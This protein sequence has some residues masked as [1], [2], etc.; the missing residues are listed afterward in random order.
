MKKISIIIPV[1]NTKIEELKQCLNSIINQTYK[2]IEVIIVNDGSTKE[3]KEKYTEICKSYNNIKIINQKNSGVSEAR[4]NG[5]KNSTGEWIMFVDSDDWLELDAC[6]KLI[7]KAKDGVEI[8]I[9]RANLCST[10]KKATQ[11]YYKNDIL[12][13]ND[14]LKNELI[15]SIFRMPKAKYHYI[16]APWAKIYNKEFLINQKILFVKGL[17]FGEDTL[18]NFMAYSAA[19]KIYFLNTETYNY[20]LSPTSVSNKYNPKIIDHYNNLFTEYYKVL[21]DN[22]KET[23][24]NYFVFA[25]I[26]KYCKRYIFN[27]E[28]TN[29]DY[30]QLKSVFNNEINQKAINYVFSHRWKDVKI[31][32]VKYR[33]YLY[34]VRYQKIKLLK[35]Y[36]KIM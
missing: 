13:D 30:G 11:S 32:S 24:F 27:I 6:E 14:L 22:Q 10:T 31:K 25:Q 28:N 3:N 1:Y 7:D 23:V 8:V 12:I 18:F 19:K 26:M 33:I 16:E 9:S 15:N 36:L 4:N 29:K 2:K 20:R 35:L 34:L 21:T 5:I 17:V